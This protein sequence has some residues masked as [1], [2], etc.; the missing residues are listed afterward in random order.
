[1]P[2]TWKYNVQNKS[3]VVLSCRISIA[4]LVYFK[5]LCLGTKLHVVEVRI[6]ELLW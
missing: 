4:L 3:A 6:P 2:P 1:M 5:V